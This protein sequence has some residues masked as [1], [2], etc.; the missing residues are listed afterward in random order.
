[1]QKKGVELKNLFTACNVNPRKRSMV[2]RD[3]MVVY[4]SNNKLVF[5]DKEKKCVV[6]TEIMFEKG[7]INC[8]SLTDNKL[9]I[10]STEGRMSIYDLINSSVIASIAVANGK[11]LKFA[12]LI[13]SGDN[14]TIFIGCFGDLFVYKLENEKDLVFVEKL[15]FGT[16]L[17][18]MAT[19]SYYNKELYLFLAC[20]DNLVHVYKTVDGKL[21]YLNSLDGHQNRVSDL[22]VKK[23]KGDLL[24]LSSSFDNYVRL[25]RL[26]KGK[27]NDDNK[28]IYPLDENDTV[29]ELESVLL[30]H[31][32]SITTVTWTSN[33]FMT[34]GLDCC[35][36]I[37]T[38]N[39]D[40]QW[41]NT[42]RFGQLYG[43]KNAFFGL[44]VNSDSTSLMTYTYTGACYSWTYN[45]KEDN[46]DGEGEFSGHFN[47]VTDLVW[48]TTG[49]FLVSCSSDQ[50]TRI[51]SQNKEANWKEI[52]RAQ[53]HGYNIN[54]ITMLR[55]GEE[56][57]DFLVC[58]A[59]EKILRILEP[60]AHFINYIN[61]W[62]KKKLKLYIP[63]KEAEK[64]LLLSED[65]LVYKTV[66]ESGQEVLGLMTKA[67]KEEKQSFYF[68]DQE[69][70]A[71]VDYSLEEYKKTPTED[72]LSNFTLWPELNKLYGH[73]Y[74][75]SIVKARKD[76]AV[77][78]SACRSQSK[79]H[80]SLIFWDIKKYKVDYTIEAHN[81]T[82][83]D[84]VFT[85]DGLVTVGR[86]RQLAYYNINSES[87]YEL[88][89]IKNAHGRLINAVS[90]CSDSKLICTGSRDKSIK[91]WKNETDGLKEVC[92][93]ACKAVVKSLEFFNEK[94]LLVGFEN[95]TISVLC[96]SSE[97]DNITVTEL[98]SMK[99]H[100][101]SVNKIVKN[102][103]KESRVVATCSED[104]SVKVFE[105][106]LN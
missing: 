12:R 44:S 48:N 10:S 7:E 6:R 55:L 21:D 93:Y 39:K 38:V 61:I 33:G 82:I 68:T 37:W 47:N 103:C 34:C 29:I 71:Q 51:Y 83:L 63:D 70:K 41:E 78:V 58:G 46:W 40:G 64:D 35:I 54:S 72:F 50:T 25:W 75:I 4:A 1:M 13:E 65:P 90:Y 81:Y 27:S 57:C 98:K 95:G 49:D 97:K 66:M 92:K 101:K 5:Y 20:S 80:S 84:L 19:C 74:E 11:S 62:G 36:C 59:D 69:T 102:P 16:N 26:T 17:L 52:S 79:K 43:N 31:S 86:D 42:S 106:E 8:I 45:S 60:P 104:F 23:D 9:L 94:T 15:D 28:N 100:G 99:I 2:E 91:L 96:L 105:I 87:K 24:I 85:E 89:D 88:K 14:S 77:L 76:G 56:Y 18:E 3:G 73:G 22:S 32:E 53:I 67:Y 30:G